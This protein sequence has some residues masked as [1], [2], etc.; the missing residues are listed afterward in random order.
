MSV[1]E[2][3]IGLLPRR[4]MVAPTATSSAPA[5]SLRD[6]DVD[7]SFRMTAFAPRGAHPRRLSRRP[8]SPLAAAPRLPRRDRPGP[9]RRLRPREGRRARPR[10]RLRRRHRGPLPRRTCPRPRT[11]RARA[12]ARLCRPGP[13]ATPPRTASR[14]PSTKATSAT[15][16]RRCGALAFDHVLANPPFHPA[17]ASAG[18]RTPGRDVAHREGAG[19]RLPTG[20][21]QACAGW[22]RAGGSSSSTGRE[23]LPEDPGG[24]RRP[25]RCRRNPADRRRAPAHPAARLLLRA[26]K[27]RKAPLT[28]CQSLNLPR[29]QFACERR[30][31]LYCRGAGGAARHGSAVAGRTSEWYRTRLINL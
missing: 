20:S 9:A 28:L 8:A 19:D 31:E 14:S 11:A 24:P 23:R 18:A 12:P 29:G 4:V 25:R 6:N 1:L 3:S 10:P 16:R 17:S 15:R 7:G 30:R 22:R 13:R 5:P 2:G 21:P 26:R 27:G